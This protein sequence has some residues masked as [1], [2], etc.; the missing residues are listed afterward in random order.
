MPICDLRNDDLEVAAGP[1]VAAVLAAP[2]ERASVGPKR[3][4]NVDQ[5]PV[6]AVHRSRDPYVELATQRSR[7]HV[8]LSENWW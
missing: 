8:Y 4:V 7:M 6:G 3:V 2:G 1:T 5:L